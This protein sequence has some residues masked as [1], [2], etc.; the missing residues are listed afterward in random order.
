M[1]PDEMDMSQSSSLEE[2]VIKKEESMEKDETVQ[3]NFAEEF[4]AIAS[5]ID[6]QSK[7]LEGVV[8][9]MAD[10]K[11]FKSE[12]SE[13]LNKV[14]EVPKVEKTEE[15]V[16]KTEEKVEKVEVKEAKEIDEAEENLDEKSKYKIVQK[17]KSFTIERKYR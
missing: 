3:V 1:H 4:K 7:V 12:V 11:N 5:K 13:K 9:D 15:K 17:H 8:A 6:A 2:K 10:L 14:N 16:E